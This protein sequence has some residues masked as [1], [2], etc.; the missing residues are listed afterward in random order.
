VKFVATALFV[1]GMLLTPAMRAQS[2]NNSAANAPSDKDMTGWQWANFLVLA[3]ILGY[4][5]VK[6][7]SPYLRNQSQMIGQGLD[8]A[9]QQRIQAEIRADEVNR[10]LNNLDADIELLC[11]KVFAEQAEHSARM[12][13]R[14]EMELE[15]VHSNAAQQIEIASRQARLDLQRHASR[16]AIELAEQRA[17]SRMNPEMQRA[18]TSQFVESFAGDFL[19]S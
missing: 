19:K 7:G 9:R 4:L 8:E 1:C 18:L 10:K 16:L 5:A 2:E 3:G 12:R 17:R 13:E 15:R 11:K 14:A 6:L